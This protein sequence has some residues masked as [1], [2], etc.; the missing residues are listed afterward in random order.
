VADETPIPP[1]PPAAAQ[2]VAPQ[3]ESIP[4][5]GARP[6]NA[7]RIWISVAIATI[8][9]ILLIIF[10]A[11]NSQSVK[12]SFLGIHGHIELGLAML[13][14]AVVGALVALLAGTTRIVQL[15][16][17][18]RHHRLAREREREQLQQP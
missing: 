7:G 14:A 6:T 3:P 8:L 5:G 11:Q 4:P 16:R 9:L 17:E 18:V 1:D 2:P 10:I 15:R 13:I 12:I